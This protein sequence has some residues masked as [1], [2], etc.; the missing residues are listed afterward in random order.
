MLYWL[1]KHVLLGPLLR[2]TCKPQVRGLENLPA[3]GPVI[4][5]SNHLAVADSFFLPLVVPRRVSFLAKSEYFTA[6][7]LVGRL[8]R[9]FFLGVGH[10]PVD[11]SSLRAAQPALATALQLLR[12]GAVLG[13]YPEGTRSPDGRLYRGKAGLAQVAL[14]AGVPVIPVAMT[15]TDR[16]NPIGSRMWRPARV[17]VTLGRPIDLSPHAGGHADP[18]VLRA[19]T[20]EVMQ[21]LQRLSGQEYVDVY[22][23][24]VRS[25]RPGDA[26][27]TGLVPEVDPGS[28]ERP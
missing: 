8:R 5:A 25:A 16:V 24:T 22:A 28:S 13:I 18:A 17:V 9:W 6:P 14:E 4:L 23:S 12:R 3:E 7:G 1:T 15:G 19:A 27:G 26:P 10:V 21:A 2:V 11:R 20:D